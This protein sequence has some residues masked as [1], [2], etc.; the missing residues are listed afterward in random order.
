MDDPHAVPSRD[1][2]TNSGDNAS[3]SDEVDRRPARR[4]LWRHRLAIVIVGIAVIGAGVLYWLHARNF[5]TTDDAFVDGYVTQMAPRVAG[6]VTA[7]LFT[8]NQHV[9]AG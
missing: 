3:S 4:S 2:A 8:D 1:H 9:K 6:Q 7:L 5:E